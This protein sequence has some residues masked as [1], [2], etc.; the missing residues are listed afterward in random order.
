M[1]TIPQHTGIGTF[2]FHFMHHI[3]LPR[4]KFNNEEIERRQI[5][6]HESVRP[7]FKHTA[8]NSQLYMIEGMQVGSIRVKLTLKVS[9]M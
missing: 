8:H 6:S 4:M 9:S 1:A 7:S 5:K 2:V 3:N